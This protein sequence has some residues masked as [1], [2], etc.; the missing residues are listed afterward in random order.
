MSLPI[1]NTAPARISAMRWGAFTARHL[2]CADSMSLKAIAMPAALEPG[3]LVTLVR[4]RT[5]ANVDPDRVG[6]ASLDP[7]LGGVV[8]EREQDVVVLG[9]LGDRLGPLRAVEVL[10]TP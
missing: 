3:P 2:A 9:D 7:V 5:V 8:V 6:R 1:S 4:S 10:E